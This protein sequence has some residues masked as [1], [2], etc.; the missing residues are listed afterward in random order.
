MRKPYKPPAVTTRE[1][2]LI[3]GCALWAELS[4][5]R[6]IDGLCAGHR[7]RKRKG[8]PLETPLHRGLGRR[9]SPR[10]ALLE[11]ALSLGEVDSAVDSDLDFRRALDRLT[12]A[13][14]Q[15]A[16]ARLVR[17]KQTRRR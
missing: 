16:R 7:Y 17:G 13:A 1:K 10:I 12:H 15:Y 5:G 3:E 4:R 9:Q 6:P 2:C 8:L 14:V 11:A